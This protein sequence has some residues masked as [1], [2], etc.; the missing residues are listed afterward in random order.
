MAE[1]AV[2]WG[3]TTKFGTVTGWNPIGATINKTA[4]RK[5]AM[6]GIGNEVASTTVNE[7]STFSQ[8]FQAASTSAPTI[9][10]VL[11]KLVGSCILTGISITT[12]GSDFAKM[13]LTGHQ[14]EDNAHADTLNQVTHGITMSSG[15]GGI[16]FLGGTAGDAA[17][18]ESSTL[19]IQCG[20]TDSPGDDGNHYVGQNHTANATASTTWLGVP[21]VGIGEGWDKIETGTTVESNTNHV[22]TTYGGAKSLT[23]VAP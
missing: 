15:F 7:G 11:G 16:D 5:V 9:P 22:R 10:P 2:T 19:N 23:L 3:T 4:E 18:V 6:D 13:T 21:S 8:E 20:H 14:H 17:T 12:K 1:A